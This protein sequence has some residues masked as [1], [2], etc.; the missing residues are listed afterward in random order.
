MSLPLPRTALASWSSQRRCV[1]L[2]RFCAYFSRRPELSKLWDVQAFQQSR[3]VGE[4]R[5]P[6]RLYLVAQAGEGNADPTRVEEFRRRRPR[7]E[8][9]PAVAL[10]GG[11]RHR[12]RG[13]RRAAE[14]RGLDEIERLLAGPGTAS[15]PGPIPHTSE[16]LGDLARAPRVDREDL[17]AGPQGGPTA[18]LSRPGIRVRG[19][20]APVATIR[21]AGKRMPGSGSMSQNSTD[22]GP[23]VSWPTFSAPISGR[24]SGQ[25]SRPRRN[26]RSAPDRREC[27]LAGAVSATR[28]RSLG[29]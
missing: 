18:R 23:L 29:R 15:E 6:L 1:A 27:A 11:H 28:G 10:G 4:G 7:Q 8:R 25:P 13:Q 22:H 21:T 26:A 16:A 19:A 12:R 2:L 9:G 17:S 24:G 3:H 14:P 20:V 5:I